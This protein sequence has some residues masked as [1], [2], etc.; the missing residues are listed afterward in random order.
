MNGTTEMGRHVRPPR[1]VDC[2]HAPRASVWK[3]EY[4]WPSVAGPSA[5]P[6]VRR[7]KARGYR[8]AGWNCRHAGGLAVSEKASSTLARLP[9]A[10]AKGAVFDSRVV[11]S[12]EPK[13][14]VGPIVRR[15]GGI[16]RSMGLRFLDARRILGAP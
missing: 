9:R 2:R 13:G 1:S 6:R 10:G 5:P 7:R 12:G 8:R 4:Q 11:D 16:R 15:G 14:T 3:G